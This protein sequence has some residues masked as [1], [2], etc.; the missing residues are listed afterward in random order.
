MF[1]PDDKQADGATLVIDCRSYASNFLEA[2]F[3][4]ALYKS[5]ALFD[6]SVCLQIFLLPILSCSDRYPFMPI[7][8]PTARFMV[9][10]L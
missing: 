7:C 6:L 2:Q 3:F 1:E 10:D 8:D 4:T 5:V 9:I